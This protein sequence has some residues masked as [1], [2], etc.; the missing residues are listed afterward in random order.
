MKA[1]TIATAGDLKRARVCAV[2]SAETWNK[3]G[4][5][6]PDHNHKE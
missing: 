1:V 6:L 2:A 4:P 3:R 5:A